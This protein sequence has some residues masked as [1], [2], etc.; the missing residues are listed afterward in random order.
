VTDS[1]DSKRVRRATP[2]RLP[3]WFATLWRFDT[4][5]AWRDAPTWQ[6]G[7]RS[8]IRTLRSAFAIA[9]VWQRQSGRSA[10]TEVTRVRHCQVERKYAPR[11]KVA[12]YRSVIS[13]RKNGPPDPSH[14][15]GHF[16]QKPR[17]YLNLTM[18][19][20]SLHVHERSSS[21]LLAAIL[22]AISSNSA[23]FRRAN[24]CDRSDGGAPSRNP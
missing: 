11:L 7:Y 14:P 12:D 6:A 2:N 17:F 24:V 18:P 10:Q 5:R 15:R 4:R 23:I 20:R 1:S 19:V 21:S 8:L 13:D 16:P 9:V 3:P 22:R